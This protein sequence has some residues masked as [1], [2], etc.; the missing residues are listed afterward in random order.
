MIA[1]GFMQYLEEFHDSESA[2]NSNR[3][4]REANQST[5]SLQDLRLVLPQERWIFFMA[6]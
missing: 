4:L 2:E 6:S 5:Q 1:K 3:L